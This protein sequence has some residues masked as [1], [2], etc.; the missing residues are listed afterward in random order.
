MHSGERHSVAFH[1]FICESI[2]FF[3]IDNVIAI[4]IQSYLVNIHNLITILINI[5]KNFV[6]ISNIL[7]VSII[8]V[9]IVIILSCRH[10]TLLD[11]LSVRWSVGSSFR[12]DR[13]EKWKNERSRYFLVCSSDRSVGWGVDGGWMPLHT[14]S[15]QYCDPVSLA[16]ITGGMVIISFISIIDIIHI[17]LLIVSILKIVIIIIIVSIIDNVN[18]LL[19]ISVIDTV[20]IV[21][22]MFISFRC[23]LSHS[24]RTHRIKHQFLSPLK[25]QESFLFLFES[26]D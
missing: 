5:E 6:I 7:I 2:I 26:I 24:D 9:D 4:F 3:N 17:L 15:H 21:F 19:I 16:N 10:V 23:R 18:I 8:D 1:Q 13:I 12:G 25:R 11:T 22:I 14:R 20:I